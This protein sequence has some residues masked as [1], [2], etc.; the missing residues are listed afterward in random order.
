MKEDYLW[1]KTGND[2]EIE[3]LE[4]AL[5]AFR[6]VETAS[7]E[8]PAKVASF[9][10][11]RQRKT[12]RFAIA[13]AACIA[14]GVISLGVWFQILKNNMNAEQAFIIETQTLN[15]GVIPEITP[16]EENFPVESLPVPAWRETVNLNKPFQRKVIKTRQTVPAVN[17][18]KVLNNQAAK[19][20]TPEVILTEE[21]QYAYN[22]LILALSITGSK[23]KIVK[24]TIEGAEEKIAIRENEH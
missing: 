13:A 10:V 22:Q 4:N 16:A 6:Y 21:E 24:D 1:D 5:W 12:F 15:G 19:R 2:P 20:P 11:R 7:P 18:Q 23:L 14:F 8:I 9:P 17:R 3:K